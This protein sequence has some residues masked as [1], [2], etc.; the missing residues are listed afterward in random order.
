MKKF[1]L[2][3][4][5]LLVGAL[6]FEISAQNSYFV[7][8][9]GTTLTEESGTTIYIDGGANSTLLLKD[10][11]TY[12]PSFLQKGNVVFGASVVDSM[13][14]Q[15]Y[16]VKDEWHMV[17]SSVT[18]EVNGA[19]M[20]M[21]LYEYNEVN[22]TWDYLNLPTTIPLQ[23]GQGYLVWN[24][25]DHNSNS[26]HNEDWPLPGDSAEHKGKSI[27]NDLTVNLS[28]TS[29][30]GDGWNLVGNPYTC[31]V[32]WNNH[33]DW[34]LTNVTPTAYFYDGANG[35]YASYNGN[36]GTYTNNKYNG[37]I[38]ATQGFFVKATATGGSITFPA[39]Q[40]LHSDTNAF[41]KTTGNLTYLK[42]RVNSEFGFDETIIGFDNN[43][44]E[45]I[46]ANYDAYYLYGIGNAPSLYTHDGDIQLA[47]NFYEDIEGN[48]VVALNFEAKENGTYVLTFD[49][50]DSFDFDIPIWLEDKNEDTFTNLR[51]ANSY[52]FSANINDDFDRFNVH[53]ANPEIPEEDD[54]AVSIYSYEKE[55]FVVVPEEMANSEIIVYNLLGEKVTAREAKAGMNTIAISDNNQYYIV[56][57]V[58]ENELV[59]EKV[60]IH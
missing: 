47:H 1:L 35:N 5:F 42:T 51:H 7:V 31:A 28:Y 39:S 46:D 26:P 55:I 13:R 43:T 21:Y 9:P 19:Y 45:G 18:D 15:Q 27:I 2:V 36:T 60:F 57:L 10:D 44:V 20:W 59:T 32:D 14:V 41:L 6:I 16:L 4:L 25:N 40:R 30:M 56:K 33:V 49:N 38:P 17:S 12:T 11:Y 50:I 34:G 22:A 53:F 58:G 37:Y 52:S 3:N 48:E 8:E 24:H 23:H 29:G 54:Y